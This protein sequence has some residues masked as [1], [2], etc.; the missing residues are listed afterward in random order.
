M[1]EP[2]LTWPQIKTTKSSHSR[3]LPSV[4][5]HWPGG[6]GGDGESQGATGESHTSA[7]KYQAVRGM[8]M[9]HAVGR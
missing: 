5:G 8:I 3:I 7:F 1:G 2:G 4:S 6:Y 9:S